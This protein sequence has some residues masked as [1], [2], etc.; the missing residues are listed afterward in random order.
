[1]SSNKSDEIKLVRRARKGDRTAFEQ[2][3]KK[4][5]NLINV[6][7]Y[8]HTRNPQETRDLVQ[9]VFLRALECIGELED[10]SKFRSWLMQIARTKSWNWISRHHNMTSIE[11]M[12]VDDLRLLEAHG[13]S[14]TPHD[15]LSNREV[16]SWVLRALD[17]LNPRYK[18]VIL[19]KYMEGLS[20]E[21][22][23]EVLDVSIATVRSRLY[24]AKSKLQ[25]ILRVHVPNVEKHLCEEGVAIAPDISDGDTNY[26]N[27]SDWLPSLLK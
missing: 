26:L 8:C 19:L 12:D 20:Y 11:S 22:I 18:N 17:S 21:K 5:Y 10:L 6:L 15:T 13:G 27:N 3:V 14:H 2:L 7:V 4:H 23:A 1:M 9:E 16:R 24:R 25:H